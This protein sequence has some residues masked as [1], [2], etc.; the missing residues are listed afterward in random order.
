MSN[1]VKT[2]LNKRYGLKLIKSG[3]P[4]INVEASTKNLGE[5]TFFFQGSEEIEKAFSVLLNANK[6]FKNMNGLELEDFEVILKLLQNYDINDQE[7][8][9][10]MDKIQA[11]IDQVYDVKPHTEGEIKEPEAIADIDTNILKD[12]KKSM[13]SCK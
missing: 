12:L 11:V 7:R 2:V 3:F 4:L 1:S 10:T 13:S 8:F 5:V 6:V 9:S